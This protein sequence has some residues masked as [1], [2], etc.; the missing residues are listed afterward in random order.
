MSRRRLMMGLILSMIP[1]SVASAAA[2]PISPIVDSATGIRLSL[3]DRILLGPKPT[4]LGSTWTSGDGKFI[5]DT[6]RIT[7]RTLG[8]LETTF[9]SISGRRITKEVTGNDGFELE[10]IDR[11]RTE[12]AL[13]VRTK[14]QEIRG[15]SVTFDN[16]FAAPARAIVARADLF[17]EGAAAARTVSS[18]PPV[19]IVLPTRHTDNI[20]SVVFSAG[21][22]RFAASS[23]DDGVIKLWDVKTGRLIRNVDRIDRNTKFWSVDALS[24]DGKRLLGRV[25][26]DVKLWDTITG[27]EILTIPSS[28]ATGRDILTSPQG[29]EDNPAII[30]ND[31]TRIIATRIDRTATL[32]DG[33]TGRELATLK[34]VVAAAFSQD[35]KRIVAGKTDKTVELLDSATGQRIRGLTALDDVMKEAVHS[36]DDRR[37]SIASASGLIRL[38]DLEANRLV[39]ERRAGKNTKTVFSPDGAYWAFIDEKDAVEIL[40]AGTTDIIARFKR[41]AKAALARFSRDNS[42]LLFIPRVGEDVDWALT[43]VQVSTGATVNVFKGT[44]GWG[45]QLG[46]Q[47]YLDGGEEGTLRLRDVASWREVRA[48]AGQPSLAAAAFSSSGGRIAL[49]RRADV[50]VLDAE[51]G[52]QL[53]TCPVPPGHATDTNVTPLAA[54]AFSSDGRRIAYGVDNKTIIICDVE[55]RTVVQSLTGHDEEIRTLSFS[56]DDRQLISGDNNGDNG[57]VKVWDV[58]SGRNLRTFKLNATFANVVAFSPDGRRAFAGTDNNRIHIWDLASGRE[59]KALRMLIGPVSSMAISPDGRRVAGGPVSE[60]LVKQWDVETGK[61]TRRLESGIAG[62]YVVVADVKYSTMG[63]RVLAAISNNQM[64][65]WDIDSG[66]KK[67]EVSYR[68]QDFKSI[69]FSGDGRRIES[70]DEAGV[71][72]HW[73]RR[74]GVLLVTVFP[75]GDG[76]WLRL[77]PEGFFDASPNAAANLSVVRGLEITGI[78]Q[79][80]QSLYRPELVREKLA[81][82]PDG[83]VKNAAAKL[84]LS[85]V[86]ASGA[87]PR[88]AITTPGADATT[89]EPQIAAEAAITDAGGGIG[90]IEWRVNGVTLGVQARGLASS[91][92]PR[93]NTLAVTQTLP[94]EVGENLIEVVAYNAKDLIASPAARLR[95][96]RSGRQAAIKPRL[97]VLAV[98]VNEYWDDRLKLNFAVADARAMAAAFQ[99]VAEGL[100]ESAK[101]TTILDAEV[102]RDHLGAVFAQVAADVRPA[103]VFV[104]FIAGHGRTL[105]GRYY[106]VPQDFRYQDESSFAKSAISQ[107]QWQQWMSAIQAR[108]S[109][110][111]YDTC[112][113]GTVT[114]DQP[115]SRGLGPAEEQATAI[116]KL[117]QA[118]GR[119]VL[120]ASAE[121]QPALEGYRGHGVLSYAVLEALEKGPVNRDGLIE[122]IGLIGFVDTEVPTLSYEAFKRRQIPQTKFNG[123]NFAFG[124]PA[125]VLSSGGETAPNIPT[126]P[127]HVLITTAEVFPEAGGTSPGKQ[128]LAPGTLVTFV[129]TQ[130][131][132]TLVARDGKPLGYVA[133]HD[134]APIQ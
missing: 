29:D 115:A 38:W 113:S 106:F 51:T 63:D 76:A 124:K 129:R 134:L 97:H 88:V 1:L 120:A 3:P 45:R 127:T 43:T 56:S 117:K 68:D 50:S 82:D 16:R 67:F 131:G 66:Q 109:I 8:D 52:Q 118:T 33:L 7:D 133:A 62:R 77:T 37:V 84:D 85:Q 40:N 61:E 81:G 34:N 39:A 59:E 71:L 86:M 17:P 6:F 83:R 110:L 14:G 32:Y 107:D 94:L 101:V 54:V 125:L 70:V 95:L 20:N 111:I 15:T 19:E 24:S 31:G 53:G 58:A 116:E 79:V 130:Q 126:K 57:A 55:K 89:T 48:F 64:L 75:L 132:W 99:K 35:G 65:A 69:A 41:P 103:D 123:S 10:G 91:D 23:G 36:P 25:S 2:Q 27:R 72:R 112:E 93:V 90:H 92:V 60:L 119:T 42:L 122:V 5:V 98:G 73:D 30:S 108:K 22:D 9:R 102:T 4:K 100:Y 74:S 128:K 121:T 26:G 78:D 21:E 87:A 104:L 11:G 18:A 46:T 13:K 28:D 44:R 80:Y 96:T 114:A 12:F 49:A 105:D 47:F